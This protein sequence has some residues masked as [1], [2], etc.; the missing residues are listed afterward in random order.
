MMPWVLYSGK[1][2]RSMPGRP[3]LHADD[4]VGDLPG[5]VEHLRLGVQ[6]RHLVVDDG[7][8]DGVVAAGN[9]TV[10]H[11]VSPCLMCECV[12]RSPAQVGSQ[13]HVAVNE[14]VGEVGDRASGDDLA[15][16]HH[17]E[18]SGRAAR[19]PDV[20]LDEDDGDALLA[21]ERDDASSIC[22][23]ML[24]WMPSVGSSSRARSS[25]RRASARAMASCCC[26]PPERSPPGRSRKSRSIGKQPTTSSSMS[27]RLFGTRESAEHDVL[28]DGEA[29]EEFRGPAARSRCRPG[30][31]GRSAGPAG[32]RRRAI[33]CRPC[34]PSGPAAPSAASS[35]PR[36]CGRARL[37]NPPSRHIEV[38]ARAGRGY[39]RSRRRVR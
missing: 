3:D 28:A 16:L 25:G 5:V 21:V 23:T 27:L 33:W 6:A 18:A 7:D 13:R 14:F 39:C 17:D 29:R 11:V 2:T 22:S 20:L 10:K 35:C 37:M 31:G 12:G 9:I 26:W 1:I 8:A 30:H 34:G 36:R 4:H 19:E 15:L 32:P 38:D 24:G